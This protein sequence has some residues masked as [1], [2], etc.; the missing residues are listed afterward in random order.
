MNVPPDEKLTRFISSK[1]GFS[2]G[3]KTVSYRAFIPPRKNPQEISV[4]RITTLTENEIWEIGKEYVQGE[5]QIKARADFLAKVV[6][7]N[8]LIV[9]ADTQV[10]ELHANISPLPT[11]REDRDEILRELALA[12]ELVISPPEET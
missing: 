8:S 11:D 10:H 6:Y 9:I 1:S 4:Y 12:S 7:E 5:N 3:K 2:I